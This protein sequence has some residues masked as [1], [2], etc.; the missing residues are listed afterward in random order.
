MTAP[1]SELRYVP[2]SGDA[3]SGGDAVAVLTLTRPEVANAFNDAVIRDLTAHLRAAAGAPRCRALVLR[4]RGKHFS[5]G[6]DLGWMK[7]SAALTFDDNVRDA[8]GLVELFDALEALP[9]PSLAVVTGSAFGGAVGLAAAAD[10]AIATENARFSLSEVKLGLLPAVILPYLARKMRPGSLRRLA[11]TGRV[12]SAPEAQ[13]AGLVERVVPEGELA[14]AVRDELSAFLQGAPSAQ[15]ALK[16]LLAHVVADSGRQGP[17]TAQAIAA[18][19]TSAS[20]QAG[21]GAFFD[22]RPAPWVRTLGADF[23][24]GDQ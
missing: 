2:V 9:F 23:D 3:G 7:A 19:R 16:T 6:A 1:T 13:A 15:A 20:G 24:L 12:F 18:A 21:L 11:L 22:K 8:H 14:A 17:H 5:A 4:G 10:V